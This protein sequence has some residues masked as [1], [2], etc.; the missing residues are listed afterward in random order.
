M[1]WGQYTTLEEMAKLNK[2]KANDRNLTLDNLLNN[3]D[4]FDKRLS[5]RHEDFG[6]VNVPDGL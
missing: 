3:R 4:E 6:L 2:R 5:D 1:N